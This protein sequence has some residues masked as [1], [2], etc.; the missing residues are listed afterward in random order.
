MLRP[1]HVSGIVAIVYAVLVWGLFGSPL[2]WVTLGE[3]YHPD[4]PFLYS[5]EGYDGQFTYA[6]AQNPRDV[7][8]RLD[9]PAYRFQR[10]LLPLLGYGI[11]AGQVALVPYALMV[12]NLA[13]VMLGTALLEHWLVEHH[14]NRWYALGYGLAF[15]IIGGARLTLSEPL[16]YSLCLGAVLAVRHERIGIAG[17]LGL[18]ALLA[19]ETTLFFLAGIGLQYLLERR[20]RE[21]ITFATLTLVPFVAWQVLLL[22]WFGELGIGSGGAGA[23]GFEWIPL[24]GLLE[25]YQVGGMAVFGILMTLI[26]PFVLLP[27]AW[28]GIRCWQDSRPPQRW[29]L[30]TSLLFTNALIMLFVPFSTYREINGLFRFIIGLQLAVILYASERRLLRP[31][32]L[33]IIWTVPTIILLYSDVFVWRGG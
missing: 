28:A 6:I 8:G 30:T 26:A 2:A 25:I 33:G 23:S 1:Y 5:A 4:E 18:L 11:A 9:A 27:T 31:L 24:G 3:T 15:G 32:R 29:T 13:S 22:R 7:G 12:V 16:A 19:K 20:W 14:R 17:A 21:G 10:I